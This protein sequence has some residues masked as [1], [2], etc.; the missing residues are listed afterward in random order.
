M[1]A[2]RSA[3]ATEFASIATASDDF[4]TF[5]RDGYDARH[6]LTTSNARRGFDSVLCFADYQSLQLPG[7]NAMRVA[8]TTMPHERGDLEALAKVPALLRDI[9]VPHGL[10]A[11]PSLTVLYF[12]ASPIV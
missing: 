6:E 12:G 1:L 5:P 4:K 2:T 3:E 7:A 8:P 11:A 9:D 10:P